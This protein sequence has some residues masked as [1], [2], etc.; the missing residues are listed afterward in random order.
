[1]AAG[2]TCT[3]VVQFLPTAVG[4]PTGS[5]TISGNGG[6]TVLPAVQLKGSGVTPT[7]TASIGPS[8]VAFGNETVGTT[9]ATQNLT[10]T[11][12]G[13]SALGGM[14]IAGVNAPF[15]RVTNGGFPANAPNCTATLAVGAS[16]TVKVAFAPTAAGAA[17][18]TVVVGGTG[19]THP[20]N[21]A[22]AALTGTGVAPRV[23]FTSATNP[24]A[25]SGNTLAFGN[26]PGTVSSTL[27][28]KVGAAGSVAFGTAAVSGNRFS[29]G[30]DTC[31]GH[32]IAANASCAITVTFNGS[33][34][35]NRTGTLT[36]I[37]STGAAVAAALNLT[38]S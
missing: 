22:S 36:V 11:N 25:L 18:A 17:S 34:N 29:K 38:G 27:T 7:Y 28:L 31:S 14:G 37:D 21:S 32:T 3:I 2:A 16:C 23:T 1:L 9:S 4:S 15:T 5:V 13:N 33:G 6:S 24:G 12:T 35:T 8:P 30:A 19:A 20:T 26:Q 10:V